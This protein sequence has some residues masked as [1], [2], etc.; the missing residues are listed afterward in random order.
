MDISKIPSF[1]S[2]CQSISLGGKGKDL[3]ACACYFPCTCQQSRLPLILQTL[4]GA[5]ARFSSSLGP[6]CVQLKENAA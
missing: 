5:P 6:L 3:E 2:D 1:E 4:S